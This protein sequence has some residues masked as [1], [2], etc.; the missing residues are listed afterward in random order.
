MS[1]KKRLRQ[2]HHGTDSHRITWEI[3]RCLRKKIWN[4][5]AHHLLHHHHLLHPRQSSLEEKQQH[6]SSQGK[7]PFSP[8]SSLPVLLVSRKRSQSVEHKQTASPV[9]FLQSVLFVASS[10]PDTH[11]PASSSIFSLFRS[12]MML[13][14]RSWY[15]L[16]TAWSRWWYRWYDDYDDDA[17]REEE[18]DKEYD[19]SLQ[20]IFFG[21]LIL[22]L[23]LHPPS[24]VSWEQRLCVFNKN[25]DS[26]KTTTATIIISLGKIWQEIPGNKNS[27]WLKT[28]LTEI[29]WFPS[30][31]YLTINGI[32]N[33]GNQAII[34]IKQQVSST[35]RT[36][37]ITKSV[38]GSLWHLRQ[39]QQ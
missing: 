3:H 12:Q 14:M 36:I 35:Q 27:N 22:Y 19:L 24:I 13:L 33:Q 29:I 17:C 38:T 34:A 20:V 25:L 26:N 16:L 15:V 5:K 8:P 37:R 9:C 31:N 7:Q 18:E 1:S 10:E 30:S 21:L 2:E 39:Q 6:P 28:S 32:Q 23:L 4:P 11:L